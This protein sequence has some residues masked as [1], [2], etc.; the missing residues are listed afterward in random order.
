MKTVF[1]REIPPDVRM[2][3]NE[4]ISGRNNATGTVTLTANATTTTLE[5]A[6]ISE[7]SNVFLTPK[8]AN[9]SAEL[10]AGFLYIDGYTSGQCTIHHRN[11]TTTDRTF[12]YV[13]ETGS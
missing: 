3:I 13:I 11:D 5:N 10:A 4:L 6:N 7:Y 9:A 2:A 1:N 12:G 8:T